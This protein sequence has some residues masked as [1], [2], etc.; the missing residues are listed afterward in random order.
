[1][2][3]REAAEKVI[4]GGMGMSIGGGEIRGITLD[5]ECHVACNELGSDIRVSGTVV[6]ELSYAFQGGFGDVSLLGGKSTDGHEHG[7]INGTGIEE[8]SAEHLLDVFG[9]GGI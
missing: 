4:A 8:Q 7:R 2:G 9:V 6:E 5:M 3:R 1:M